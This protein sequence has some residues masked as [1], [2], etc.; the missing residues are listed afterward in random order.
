MERKR[1]VFFLFDSVH[2][3]DLAGAV[4]VFYEAGC[5]GHPYELRYVSPY[6]TPGTSSGLTFTQVEPLDAVAI[7]PDDMVIVAGMDLSKWNRADD[8]AWMPW[9]QHAAA[10]GA[11][12]C[13]VCTAAFALAAAGLLDGR[14]CTTHWAY[15]DTLQQRFPKLH[16]IENRLFVKS[17]NIYTSAGIS[18]GIDLAL[19]L[20]EEHY[21][22]TFAY[23][24]AKDMVV[25]I[26]RDGAATQH[27]IHLQH[28][29]HINHQIHKVQDYIT[30]HL[31][32]KLT[33]T[34]LAAM[35][36]MSSRNLTRL[37]KST[38]G[39]TIGEYIHDLREEKAVQLLKEGQ[40]LSWVANACGISSTRQLSR[41][42]RKA[43]APAKMA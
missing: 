6:T 41:L 16:V 39:I 23:T 7:Q 24:V 17:D 14:N 5:C 25:Y 43:G 28:R 36:Y 10:V 33:I 20:V 31:H 32:V 40:K 18:T 4:T 19:F 38:T 29:Q 30:H 13:S 12:V 22:P 35:V 11:T 37:F 1:A 8:N 21:G 42:A 27:S 9:L 34:D 2:L 15:T 3:L 26:R